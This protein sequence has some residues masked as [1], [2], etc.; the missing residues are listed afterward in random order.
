MDF[1]GWDGSEA[2]FFSQVERYGVYYGGFSEVSQAALAREKEAKALF[3]NAKN[4]FEKSKV[5]DPKKKKHVLSDVVPPKLHLTSYTWK[6]FRNWVE[7]H[8][9][10]WK[11][12]RRGK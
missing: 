2:E 7:D 1:F 10:G 11:A 3:H 9:P 6:T 4:E 5:S 12:K 8:H